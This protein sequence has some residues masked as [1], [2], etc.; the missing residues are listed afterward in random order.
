MLL[1]RIR[2]RRMVL[3]LGG[4]DVFR[5]VRCHESGVNLGSCP[6]SRTGSVSGRVTLSFENTGKPIIFARISNNKC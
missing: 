1:A 6:L 3:G 2:E 4:N 5:H